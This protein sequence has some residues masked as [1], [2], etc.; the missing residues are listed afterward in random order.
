MGLDRCAVLTFSTVA[1]LGATG[2]VCLVSFNMVGNNCIYERARLKQ[3]AFLDLEMQT[4]NETGASQAEDAVKTSSN[5]SDMSFMFFLVLTTQR[6]GST[7]FGALLLSFLSK[8]F[9]NLILKCIGHF[10]IPFRYPLSFFD[11]GSPIIVFP[12]H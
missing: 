1:L 4:G 5:N 6:S 8:A 9:Q 3:S 10:M 2:F 12:Y 7:L 11:Q